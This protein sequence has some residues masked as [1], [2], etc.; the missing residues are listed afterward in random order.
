M[1]SIISVD[2]IRATGTSTNAITIDSSNNL[3][4]ITMNA[5]GGTA[6]TSVRQGLVKAWG[7]FNG[8]GTPAYDDS[9]NLGSITDNGTGNYTHAFTNNMS[10]GDYAKSDGGGHWSEQ[11][12]TDSSSSVVMKTY[13]TS[14]ALSDYTN[15]TFTVAG[16]L[17]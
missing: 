2:N 7:R 17:A 12:T 11:S 10:N 3:G 6:T 5:E 1:A 8:Q 14:P 15:V 9:F 4:D 16:D 13:S